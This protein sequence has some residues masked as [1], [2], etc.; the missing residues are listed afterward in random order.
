MSRDY[1]EIHQD[2]NLR[3]QE[4]SLSK[5]GTT[6]NDAQRIDKPEA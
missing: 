4:K 5:S 3:A 6:Y 2:A 1:P